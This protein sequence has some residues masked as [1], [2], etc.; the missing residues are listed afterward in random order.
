MSWLAVLADGCEVVVHA[1]IRAD[2]CWQTM[3]TDELTS[4]AT[5]PLRR[6]IGR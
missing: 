1:K 3:A 2:R 4:T 5:F 6:A